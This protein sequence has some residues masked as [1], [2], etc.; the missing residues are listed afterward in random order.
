M[1][2]LAAENLAAVLRGEEPKSPVES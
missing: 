2:T 1:A